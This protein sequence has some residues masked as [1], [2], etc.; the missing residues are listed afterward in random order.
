[1]SP[2][3]DEVYAQPGALCALLAD[4]RGARRPALEGALAAAG[5]GPLLFAGMGSSHFA[6]LAV[7]ARLAAGGVRAQAWE[8]GELLHYHAACCTP[9]TVLVAVSQSGES[10]ETLRAAQTLTRRRCLI[11]VSNEPNSGLGRAGDVVLPLCAGAESSISTKTYS[12]TLAL[13][14]LLVEGLA[15]Q[16]VQAAAAALE[17][18]AGDMHDV[19]QRQD[20]VEGAADFL[21]GAGF[22]YFV[23]RGPALAAAHQGA[24]TFNEGA[25]LPATALPGGTFRHGPFELIGPDF[26]AVFL[27]PRGRTG[28]LTTVMAQE[29]AGAGG[30]VLLLTDGDAEPT[31]GLHVLPLPARGEDLF[32]LQACVPLELLLYHVARQRGLEAGIFRCITKVTRRE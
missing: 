29:V 15:G 9:E 17:T 6:A 3:L 10:A 19:L 13:L 18:A 20:D 7:Q 23:A 32:A 22:L 2:F 12:N 8:A 25:R 4:Y 21:S 1:M 5:G 26:A 14:H 16:D 28:E 30:R 11:S 27:A 31:R 24:L